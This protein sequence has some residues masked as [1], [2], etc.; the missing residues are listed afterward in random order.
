MFV[1]PGHN[2]VDHGTKQELPVLIAQHGFGAAF[3]MWHETQHV[4]AGIANPGNVIEGTVG[5]SLFRHGSVC[6]AIPEHD[7]GIG[8]EGGQ[9]V[10]GSVW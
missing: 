5:I 10:T 8:L 9:G 7:L 4:A 2:R 6:P 1:L 3:G